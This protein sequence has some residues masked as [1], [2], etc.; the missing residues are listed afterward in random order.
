V[1]LKIRDKLLVDPEI[2]RAMMSLPNRVNEFGY[3][4]WGFNPEEAVVVG[5][6]MK[7]VYDYFRPEIH[8]VERVPDGRVMLVANHSGQLPLDG[9]V[10]GGA[11][12][13]H[14]RPPRL[15]RPMI[16]RWLPRLPYV[17]ELLS[18]AGCVVGDPINCRNLLLDDQAILVFP[19]G[20][21]GSGKTWK[22]RYKLQPFGRGFMRLSL[23]TGAPIVP[24]AVIGGEESI[25][26]VHNFAWGAKLLGMPYLPIHPLVPVLGPLAYMP[27]PVKFHI[28]FGEPMHFSGR[29]DD[30]DTTIDQ[31][32]HEV[33]STI[34]GMLDA[35][36]QARTS[37]F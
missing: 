35:G 7:R 30:E 29:F 27:L 18:R 14:G 1:S 28:Y 19:E 11:C 25:I 24:V 17:N 16:E 21:K 37:I 33:T 8:G 6:L 15:V 10:I 4:P 23:Q 9:V 3:D 32:V 34:Q 5:S 22:D 26:S 20:V 36:L 2:E 13:L 12:L 31:K